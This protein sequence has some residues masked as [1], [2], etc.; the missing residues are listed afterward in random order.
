[1]AARAPTPLVLDRRAVVPPVPVRAVPG[2][3]VVTATVRARAA[4]ARVPG[5]GPA[6]R[7]MAAVP[8]MV[9]A[10]G[11]GGHGG[12]VGGQGG[13]GQGGQRAAAV[14]AADKGRARAVSLARPDAASRFA[15]AGGRL[16]PFRGVLGRVA[17][18]VLVGAV[19]WCHGLDRLD[20]VIGDARFGLWHKAP[21]GRI[22]VVDIDKASLTLERGWPWSRTVHAALI[23]ALLAR[24]VDS[25][26]FDVDFS[27]R[28]TEEA[29]GALEAALKR[30]DGSVILTAMKQP[31]T[32]VGQNPGILVSL[33]LA[34]FAANAWPASVNQWPDPDG[35]V[36]AV[37]R[38]EIMPTGRVPSVAMLLADPPPGPDG[39]FS[40]DFGIDEPAIPHVS[41]DALLTGRTARDEIAGRKVIIGATALELGDE[42]TIPRFGLVPGVMLHA[43]AAESLIQGRAL[44]P[45]AP[46]LTVVAGALVLAAAAGLACRRKLAGH[47]AVLATAAL[48]GEAAAA[49]VQTL[50]PLLPATAPLHVGLLGFA[51]LAVG[52]EVDE[53]RIRIVRSRSEAERL[54][55]ILDRVIADN[56][57]GIVVVDHDG[58]VRAL[59]VAAAALVGLPPAEAHDRPF[60]AVLPGP[61]AAACA[62]A[63]SQAADGTLVQRPARE[64]DCTMRDGRRLTLEYVATLS[65]VP[66]PVGADGRLGP[67]RHAVCLS[68][69]DVTETR[70]AQAQLVAMARVDAL[71]GLANRRVLIEA[72]AVAL[73]GTARRGEDDVVAL[74]FL[75]LD[76]FKVVNDRLGHA[77]GDTLLMAVAARL[78]ACAE[79]GD[80]A[81]R[82]GGDEFAMLI[83]RPSLAAI[84]D[85]ADS[86]VGAVGG[87]HT[88]G[89]YEASIG[90]SVG[91]ALARGGDPRTLMRDADA[92]M[93]AARRAGGDRALLFDAAMERGA[94]DD[95]ALEQDLRDAL[96]R[97]EITVVYQRQVDLATDRVTGVEA[98]ARWHHPARGFVSPAVFIPVAERTG[99]IA[100]LGAGVLRTACRDAV[101]WPVPIRVSVNL[102]AAQLQRDD[103]VST[104]FDALAESGLPA[105][106]LDLELTESLLMGNDGTARDRL[107]RL[108]A[109]GIHLSLDDFGTG[110]SSLSYLRHFAIDKIKIDQSFVRGLPDERP[111][112]AI[113]EA[114]VSLAG[115]LGL[116]VNAEGCET[117]AQLDALRRLGMPRGPGLAPRPPGACGRH[118]GE[119]ARHGSGTLPRQ[120]GLKANDTP[121]ARAPP[122]GHR[123]P[124]RPPSILVAA[125][126]RPRDR[127]ET[128][129]PSPSARRPGP[130]RPRAPTDTVPVR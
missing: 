65:R 14:R 58:C 117:V 106:R 107:D 15:T 81:A 122:C 9:A 105:E 77:N 102:S 74:L 121:A 48:L 40:V 52:I 129:R 25:I 55:A 86:L 128:R 20:R 88:I 21:T 45:V 38:S 101:A 120:R 51:L 29:D 59:S 91:I 35:V 50:V 54:R 97:G 110:F 104:V 34:R 43:M 1:M 24:D 2:A 78:S 72:L 61:L 103:L 90:L 108:R 79:P 92:A 22:V 68:F 3:P 114:V 37:A 94:E 5:T 63:L 123:P 93:A 10:D 18:A 99:L 115:N 100:T 109:A 69:A 30:A 8:A 67:E 130:K 116:R 60:A 42:L 95:R 12:H 119:P 62:E 64:I 32:R 57:A 71:T 41:A 23:D 125:S 126:S 33:P 89:P 70:A 80:V 36:R 6:A 127:L 124:R 46:W 39:A 17:I 98:L 53:R 118:R 66:G 26:A 49:A 87:V 27:A 76:R 47:L 56:F 83:R 84:Q 16:R 31:A 19:W 111:A 75:D 73:G 85:F 82:L 28:T 44:R 96:R 113:I 4:P 7:A 112:A 13:G 11:H